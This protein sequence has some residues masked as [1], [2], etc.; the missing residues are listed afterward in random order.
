MRILLGR[1][2]GAN[3]KEYFDEKRGI[4]RVQTTSGAGWFPLLYTGWELL[5][6]DKE[7]VVI[8]L[9][10]DEDDHISLDDNKKMVQNGIALIVKTPP[11]MI[12][13]ELIERSDEANIPTKILAGSSS[14]SE[15]RHS[16]GTQEAKVVATDDMLLLKGPGGNQIAICKEGIII[17]GKLID[18]N[19]F[20]NSKSG[21]LKENWFASII[22]NTVVTAFPHYEFDDTILKNIAGL[23]DIYTGVI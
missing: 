15:E 2:Y 1:Y 19:F 18:T 9:M 14:S 4:I 11:H 5:K 13:G 6:F 17:K 16:G 21:I 23:A 12:G 22:P 3:Q 20:N 7:D 8:I 10:F